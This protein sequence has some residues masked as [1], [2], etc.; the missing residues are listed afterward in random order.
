MNGTAQ[1]VILGMLSIEPLTGYDINKRVKTRLDSFWEI[2]YSQIYP[3]LRMLE[4]ESCITKKLVISEQGPN[5]KVYSIT[6]KG[7]LKLKNWLLQPTKSE[8]FKSEA[9]LKVAFGKQ[10][11][12]D[13]IVEH[14]LDFKA[15]STSRLEKAIAIEQEIRGSLEENDTAFFLLL[16]VLL[17]KNIEKTA[18]LWADTVLKMI[19]EHKST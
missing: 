4:K 16:T 17:G 1:F 11:P 8:T 13:K 18:I 12:K 2:S 5:R 9:L 19:N 7:I 10:I 6:D 3:T 15:R 14:V